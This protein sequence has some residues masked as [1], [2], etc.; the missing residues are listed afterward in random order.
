[1]NGKTKNARIFEI[2]TLKREMA[3]MKVEYA[4][5][6]ERLDKLVKQENEYQRRISGK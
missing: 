6:K 3:D 4:D 5:K 1:M 2:Q